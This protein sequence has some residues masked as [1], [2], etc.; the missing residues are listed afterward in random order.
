MRKLGKAL[1]AIGRFINRAII[2]MAADRPGGGMSTTQERIGGQDWEND[3]P[4]LQPQI[5]TGSRGVGYSH[6]PAGPIR[7]AKSGHLPIGCDHFDILLSLL[8]TSPPDL[9]GLSPI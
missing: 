2:D 4:G 8:T 3:L 1:K 7:L 6:G 5:A 9:S